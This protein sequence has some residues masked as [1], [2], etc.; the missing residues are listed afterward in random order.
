MCILRVFYQLAL[1]VGLF[2]D[3]GALHKNS[4]YVI[5]PEVWIAI[6]LKTLLAC[7]CSNP[8]VVDI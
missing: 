4:F 8:E 7:T 3:N 2:L 1:K 5:F 6:I